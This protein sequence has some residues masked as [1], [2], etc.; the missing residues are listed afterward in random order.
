M[1]MMPLSN[2]FMPDG[3]RLGPDLSSL[4][5]S[6][7]E[8]GWSNATKTCSYIFALAPKDF[9]VGILK[10]LAVELNELLRG[11]GEYPDL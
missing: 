5:T 7:P 1:D 3:L 4:K 2:H 8:A 10:F 6:A 9:H 11:F